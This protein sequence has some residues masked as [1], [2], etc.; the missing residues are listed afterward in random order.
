MTASG[1]PE[2]SSIGRGTSAV[3]PRADSSWPVASAPRYV[4]TLTR[5]ELGVVLLD[6][7]DATRPE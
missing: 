3:A 7:S 5:A 4:V 6:P 1:Q 2:T